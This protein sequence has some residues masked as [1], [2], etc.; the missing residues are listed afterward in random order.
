MSGV[1]QPLLSQ[2][3]S[4]P[5]AAQWSPWTRDTLLLSDP[6]RSSGKLSVGLPLLTAVS[7]SGKVVG[8]LDL[9]PGTHAF[10]LLCHPRS[11]KYFF[12]HIKIKQ[13][14]H[15]FCVDTTA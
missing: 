7:L 12:T 11:V 4:D 6:S 15:V 8:K 9:Q 13:D 1:V 14:N 10:Q 3:L 2:G 5:L